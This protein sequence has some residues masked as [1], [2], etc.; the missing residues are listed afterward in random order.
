MDRRVLKD[1]IGERLEQ[2]TETSPRY[3][4][5]FLE[6][7]LVQRVKVE[8]YSYLCYG[9]DPHKVAGHCTPIRDSSLY[10]NPM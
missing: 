4:V 1:F 3:F 2:R 5:L 9:V 8:N 6:L 7:L 10:E